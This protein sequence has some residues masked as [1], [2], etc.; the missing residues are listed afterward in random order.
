MRYLEERG[1]GFPACARAPVPIVPAAALFDL[2][3]AARDVRPDAAA[4]YA[5]CLAASDASIAEGMR[6]RRHGRDRRQAGRAGAGRSR[7]GSARPRASCADGTIVGA[8]VAVNAVGGGVRPA[9]GRAAA[10]SRAPPTRLAATLVAGDQH[11]HR[12]DRHDR[13]PGLGGVN[14]LAMLGHDG[15][16]LAIR[17]AHTLY[18]GDTL[19]AL[20]LP[21]PTAD[22]P[23]ST[24]RA[25][26]GG[27][28]GRG[29]SDRPRRAR[30]DAAARHPGGH[31]A[32]TL[33]LAERAVLDRWSG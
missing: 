28:R 27:G 9:T 12:R 20:S 30:G 5:A 7:A 24:L 25:R 8:L 17:P 1:V 32:V 2:A 19:F 3:S 10:P 26:P 13:A 16:A 6:R 22:A 33:E 29:R 23:T 4:G 21:R 31:D 11:D 15:L 18:D 14:R